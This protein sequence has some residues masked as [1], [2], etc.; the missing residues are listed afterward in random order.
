MK[1]DT[2]YLYQTITTG[3][4]SACSS[5]EQMTDI[6]PAGSPVWMCLIGGILSFI[7][8]TTCSLSIMY[9]L[10]SIDSAMTAYMGDFVTEVFCIIQ[11]QIE[12]EIH[13]CITCNTLLET[14]I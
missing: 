14:W 1:T 8:F 10:Y 7:S 6:T 2:F 5:C 9:L 12:Y 13:F 3:L 11:V 4:F